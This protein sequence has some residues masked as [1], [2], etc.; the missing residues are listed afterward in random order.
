MR[1]ARLWVALLGVTKT[2]VQRVEF[3]EDRDVL[4]AHVRPMRSAR[5]RCGRCGRRSPGYDAGSGRRRGHALVG[6]PRTDARFHREIA[7]LTE[8]DLLNFVT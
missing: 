8:P 4:V 3:D 5:G 2:T 7:G 1:N 6:R